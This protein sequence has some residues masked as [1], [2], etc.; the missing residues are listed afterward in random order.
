MPELGTSPGSPGSAPHPWLGQ[1]HP[2]TGHW[3]PLGHLSPTGNATEEKPMRDPQPAMGRLRG[4]T[5]CPPRFYSGE[6]PGSVVAGG[7]PLLPGMPCSSPCAA[8][9]EGRVQGWG[10]GCAGALRGFRA[11]SHECEG[12]TPLITHATWDTA[13]PMRH[14]GGKITRINTALFSHK[15]QA[16]PDFA[17]RLSRPQASPRAGGSAHPGDPHTMLSSAPGDRSKQ[18]ASSVQR[19]RI[20]HPGSSVGRGGF[21]GRWMPRGVGLPGVSLVA[22]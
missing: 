3:Q 2:H 9:G 6:K 19:G 18:A 13:F 15:V 10:D 11:A 12:H 7:F 5:H 8:G 22:G 17:G 20:K 16:K 21:G 14:G 4:V 1:C